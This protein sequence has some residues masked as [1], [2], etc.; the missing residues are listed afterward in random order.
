MCSPSVRRAC[1]RNMVPNLPAPI[2][3]T[4]TGRPAAFRSS[5]SVCRFTS[6]SPAFSRR[7]QIVAPPESLLADR[8]RDEGLVAAL[9][10]IRRAALAIHLR[11]ALEGG[12]DVDAL[13]VRKALRLAHRKARAGAIRRAVR[14]DHAELVS[15]H[16]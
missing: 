2:S 5:N 15:G 12:C 10:R 7:W 14:R 16:D 9:L 3:P 8:A 6:A 13:T 1:A 4:V 11:R